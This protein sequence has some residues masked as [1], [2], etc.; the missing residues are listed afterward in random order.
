METNVF[1]GEYSLDHWIHLLETGNIKL[2]KIQ[3]SFTWKDYKIKRL[4]KSLHNKQFIPPII[5]I[6]SNQEN[7]II[8]GQQ[9]LTSLL[10]A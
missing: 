1:Y 4:I 8:D 9:R 2:P 10:L 6:R 5:V 7:L 3:R